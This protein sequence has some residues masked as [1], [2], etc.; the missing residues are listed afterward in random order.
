MTLLPAFPHT[1]L[2][3]PRGHYSVLDAHKSA[4]DCVNVPVCVRSKKCVYV[5]TNPYINIPHE[6]IQTKEQNCKED[7]GEYLGLPQTRLTQPTTF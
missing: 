2:T 4:Y 1:T 5:S 7:V 6:K 3:T